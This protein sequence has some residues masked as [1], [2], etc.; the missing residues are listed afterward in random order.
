MAYKTP[1]VYVEEIVKFPPSVAQVETAIPAFIGYTEKATDKIN[2][3]LKGKPTRI[4]SMLA[5]ETYF[6]FAKPETTIKVTIK[7]ELIN[8]ESER[9]VLVD[10]PKNRAPFLMYYSLQMYF[11]NGGG[12]CYINSVGRYGDNLDT[13]DVKVTSINNADDF[14]TGL[15]AIRKVDEPTLLLFPDATALSTDAEFYSL[16]NDALTQ[17]NELQDRFTIIDTRAVDATSVI[18]VNIQ[19]LRDSI[20]SE[21]DYLKYG[22]AY[23]PFLKTILDYKFNDKDVILNHIDTIDPQAKIIITENV[24]AIDMPTAVTDIIATT[25][26]F[27]TTFTGSLVT[28]LAFLY[29]AALGFNI[30]DADPNNKNYDA[31]RPLTIHSHL[32]ILIENLEAL[33]ALKKAANIEAN[34]AISALADELP[35]FDISVIKTTQTNFNNLFEADGTIQEITATLKNLTINLK[36]HIDQANVIKIKNLIDSN[37]SNILEEIEKLITVSDVT[38]PVNTDTSLFDAVVSNW[39]ALKSAIIDDDGDDTTDTD[40][41]LDTNNGALHGRN[42]ASIEEL[43]NATYNKILTEI[44]NLPLELP[45]S[46]TM[47]GIYARVDSDRGV[48]KAPANVSL[49]YVEKPSV[50]ISHEDQESLNVDVVAGKSI[51]A[52]RTFTGKGVLVWGARTLAGNDN[53]WRYIPVRRFFN[54]AEESIK[55]ATEQF[56]F[57]PNDKNTWVRVKAMIDNFLTTQWKAGALAGPTPDKAFY[58]SVGLGETM[59]AQ[60]ILEGKM[61]I[62]IGMAVVRP[63]EFIILK[64]SH[65]MQEA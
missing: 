42:L 10:Q 38:S 64:F 27:G 14:K 24:N 59:T 43:D 25:G 13:S 39:D 30:G 18:D 16:Y 55:K 53:E 31:P 33:L 28:A 36:K 51:N 45:P 1:G 4:T 2:G 37:T 7:D 56:V 5:Y 48:W 62:E 32:E 15:A 50:Q 44:G 23:Y 60:D 47:A 54:M 46:S 19:N 21:K 41:G 12:P 57:E 49:N 11:A 58:V 6:G 22:A 29:D 63:A 26:S 17:C 65:K 9:S 35:I 8:G 52:I 34:A 3:D 61:V 40:I 20:S